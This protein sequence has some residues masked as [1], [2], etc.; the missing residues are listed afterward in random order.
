M[1]RSC[2]DLSFLCSSCRRRFS[3]AELAPVLDGASFARLAESVADRL[4]DRI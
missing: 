3:L 1:Q 2:L 4:A